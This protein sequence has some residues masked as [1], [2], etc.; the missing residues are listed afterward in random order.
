MWSRSSKMEGKRLTITCSVVRRPPSP[1]HNNFVTPVQMIWNATMHNCSYVLA[2]AFIL[3]TDWSHVCFSE[4]QHTATFKVAGTSQP[5]FSSGC[6]NPG[7][8]CCTI[9]G[10][11]NRQE[12]VLALSCF[13]KPRGSWR[14]TKEE[15]LVLSLGGRWKEA[16]WALWGQWDSSGFLKVN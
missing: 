5:P 2:V 8:E 6:R 10:G 1:H 14:W 15:R 16:L 13:P 11:G 12:T 4:R 7:R 3:E 9:V